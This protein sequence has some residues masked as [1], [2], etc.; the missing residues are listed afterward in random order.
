MFVAVLPVVTSPPIRNVHFQMP[1]STF[2]TEYSIPGAAIAISLRINPDPAWHGALA[3]SIQNGADGK[4]VCPGQLSR[5][6]R[7]GPMPSFPASALRES[8][9]RR[10]WQLW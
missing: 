4:L 10:R 8:S 5:P 3:A 2:R 1:G 7:I 9:L 6:I